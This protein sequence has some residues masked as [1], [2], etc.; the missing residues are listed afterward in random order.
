M[1]ITISP[2][3][4]FE[5]KSSSEWYD[6]Q[7]MGL[8]ALFIS[9][10]EDAVLRIKQMPNGFPIVKVKIRKCLFSKF[11]YAIMYDSESQ[12]DVINILVVYHQYRDPKTVFRF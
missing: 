9:D 12:E 8:G 10:F 2:K 5:L 11:P 6:E 3:A 4:V 1:K 7:E